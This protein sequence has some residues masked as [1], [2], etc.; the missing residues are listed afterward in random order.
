MKTILSYFNSNYKELHSS[1][2]PYHKENKQTN[3]QL[4]K[5]SWKYWIVTLLEMVT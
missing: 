4:L 1:G 3:K 5:F 2:E